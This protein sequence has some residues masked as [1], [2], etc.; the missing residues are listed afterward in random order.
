MIKFFRQIRLH[1]LSQ[2]RIGRYL[3]YA[4][5]EIVLVVIGILL[6]LYLNNLNQQRLNAEKSEA[7]LGEVL[8]DL[9]DL[10]EDSNEQLEFYSNK[11]KYFLLILRDTLTV[12]DCRD[13]NN[14]GIGHITTDGSNLRKRRVAYENLV[15]EINS[16]PEKYK[17][18]L[19]Q[20]NTLYT[21]RMNE[22]QNQLL[23]DLSKE[24]LKKRADNYP[25]YTDTEIN[26][27]MIHWMVN[28]FRYRNEVL[29]YY[30][31]VRFHTFHLLLDRKRAMKVYEEIAT[32]LNKPNNINS[33][34]DAEIEAIL[35]GVWKSKETG[36]PIL[37][38][39]KEDGQINATFSSRPKNVVDTYIFGKKIIVASTMYGELIKSDQ[40]YT[41]HF[42]GMELIK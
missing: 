36:N 11:D 41:L 12:E 40:D 30:T 25:W 19:K 3:A 39:L 5:G 18:I 20:L 8:L 17:D 27:A 4:A 42:K 10:I 33:A 26:E 37:T 29:Y 16:I 23:L 34:E 14:R 9:Q 31:M 2:K 35:I 7:L 24:N 38:F 6:A 21:I 13:P 28:D 1:L 22:E 32:V 15:K